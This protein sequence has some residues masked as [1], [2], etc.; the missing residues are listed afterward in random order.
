MRLLRHTNCMLPPYPALG[1]GGT[2]LAQ[3]FKISGQVPEFPEL[4]GTMADKLITFTVWDTYFVLVQVEYS[5]DTLCWCRW[6][7]RSIP[8]T[9]YGSAEH[10][11]D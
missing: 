3:S 10:E 8:I 7:S 2:F 9:K 5:T 11:S 1:D 4:S 6:L